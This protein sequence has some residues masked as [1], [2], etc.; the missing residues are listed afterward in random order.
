MYE[1][2]IRDSV[3]GDII[4]DNPIYLEIIDTPEFQR[5]RRILQLGGS[6][7][8][9][10]SAT[11]TRFS[12]SIGVYHIVGI[13]VD[14][15]EFT[16]HVSE[17]D[18]VLVKLAGLMHDLGHGPFSHTFEKITTQS[19]EQYTIDIISNKHGNIY[20]ILKKYDINP[21]NVC[22]IIRGTYK[23]K[24]INLLV[25]SQLDADRLDYLM[26]DSYNCGVD[27]A[28]LDINWIVRHI[29]IIENKIVFPYKSINA[30]ESY[31]LGR[32]HMY[33]QVY[34]HKMSILF[35]AM[36]VSWFK[37]IEELYNSGFEFKNKN[38]ILNLQPILDK[39]II[40]VQNYLMYDD[41]KMAEMFK[42]CVDESDL[43]LAD[44]SNR[45]INRKYF[46]IYKESEIR[47][48]EVKE[49]IAKKN[50]NEKYYLLK[51]H[52]KKLTVYVDGMIDGKDETIWIEEKGIVKPLSKLSMFANSMKTINKTNVEENYLFPKDLV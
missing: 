6:T 20:P 31:L 18:K 45:L 9:Y 28:A 25:S 46:A 41:Y 14:S 2:V 10:P 4:F 50:L 51:T 40:K 12:H 48:K 5:L 34:N 43:V 3:H 13:F 11:H 37:R 44:F 26:R 32:Y 35:D 47:I 27:Y 7:I 30:I 52:S 49:A 23:N 8:A 42:I 39:G 19:H 1:K 21:K 24:I 16:K 17:K 38:L 15:I 22:D 33:Q 36:F 29:K